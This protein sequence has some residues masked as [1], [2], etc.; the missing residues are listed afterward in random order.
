MVERNYHSGV[1]CGL[2]LKLILFS[3]FSG[4]LDTTK[5]CEGGC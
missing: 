3:K 1:L 4:D 2:L 5:L